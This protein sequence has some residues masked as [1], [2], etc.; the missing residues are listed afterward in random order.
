MPDCNPQNEII[1]AKMDYFIIL[2]LISWIY[3]VVT[4]DNR[5]GLTKRKRTGEQKQDKQESY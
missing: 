3:F 5:A 1:N 4:V 2:F